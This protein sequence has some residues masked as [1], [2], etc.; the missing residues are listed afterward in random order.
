MIIKS[1]FFSFFSVKIILEMNIC[2]GALK[3]KGAQSCIVG[4]P[5]SFDSLC[6]FYSCRWNFIYSDNGHECHDVVN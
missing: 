2:V 1:L 5:S 3:L 4:I 6:L